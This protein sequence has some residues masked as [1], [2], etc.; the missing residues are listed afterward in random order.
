MAAVLAAS[1]GGGV[2]YASES[3]FS[4]DSA[5][6]RLSPAFVSHAAMLAESDAAFASLEFEINFVEHE[7][8]FSGQSKHLIF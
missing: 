7:N 5:E 4:Y 2:L 6:S 8:P 1:I 3:A